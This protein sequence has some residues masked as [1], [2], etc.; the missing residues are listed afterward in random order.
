MDFL[1]SLFTLHAFLFILYAIGFTLLSS[2]FHHQSL[3][4]RHTDDFRA[5]F[6]YF[7]FF[8]LFLL[9]IPVIAVFLFS[10]K[11]MDV[12][13]GFGFRA[14]NYR[15]GLLAMVVSLPVAAVSGVFVVKDSK[16][17]K[18]YPFS[19]SACTS[20]KKFILYEL[21]YLLFYYS[22]WEFTFRGFFLFSLFE[23]M[24]RTTTALIAAVLV[25]TIISTVYHLNHPTS[26]I[27]SSF[28]G[29][30]IF[31]FLAYA[32]GSFLYTLFIHAL[33]GI[34]NDTFLYFKR[35]RTAN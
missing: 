17:N 21:F 10:P 2:R 32:T 20:S 6:L 7:V 35:Y 12:L 33:I 34:V 27:V 25:Q 30:V 26:E 23:L 14:G 8:F 31:G 3:L 24:N 16:L 15:L 4:R 5:F 18:F 29:G 28:I 13:A 9:L 11:P 22:A 19:K 1:K